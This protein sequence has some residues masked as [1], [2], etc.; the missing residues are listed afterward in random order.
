MLS[1]SLTGIKISDF[2]EFTGIKS[3]LATDWSWT[4]LNTNFL[5]V[6]ELNLESICVVKQI[7]TGVDIWTRGEAL[8][9]LLLDEVLLHWYQN[10]CL[11]GLYWY[12][13]KFLRGIK[14]SHSSLFQKS[15]IRTLL[16][17]GHWKGRYIN[18]IGL[19]EDN[20]IKDRLIDGI[21]LKTV[22][23]KANL[24]RVVGRRW[25]WC[26]EKTGGDPSGEASGEASGVPSG[27]PSCEPR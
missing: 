7:T 25:S 26:S 15:K 17:I 18:G 20:I 13:N 1:F 19:A 9:L 24:V 23:A 5:L 10:K 2:K 6:T 8:L 22:T 3:S 27:E 12:Q 16:K 21:S 4:V 14:I 11:R